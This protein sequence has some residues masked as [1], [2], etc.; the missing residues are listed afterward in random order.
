MRKPSTTV[1][2]VSGIPAPIWSTAPA[3][4]SGAGH[5]EMSYWPM[6]TITRPSVLSV[7]V[8]VHRTEPVSVATRRWRSRGAVTARSPVQ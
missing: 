8:W 3:R 5:C 4:A 2:P 6:E 7:S 1:E